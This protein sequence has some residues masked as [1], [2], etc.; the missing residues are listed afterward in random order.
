MLQAGDFVLRQFFHQ[1]FTLAQEV[2][3]NTIDDALEDAAG[4]FTRRHDGLIDNHRRAIRAR[5]QAIQGGQQQ[6]LGFSMR[7]RLAHQAAENE[8]TAPAGA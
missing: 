8:I 1:G 7:Q 5:F 3:Q 6:S 4:Q 2:A